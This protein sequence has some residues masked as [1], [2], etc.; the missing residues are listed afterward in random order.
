MKHE[1]IG[2]SPL[3]AKLQVKICI[4]QGCRIPDS[5]WEMRDDGYNWFDA[6]FY[7]YAWTVCLD[8]PSTAMGQR[9]FHNLHPGY[10]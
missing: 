6:A 9:G 1:S 7:V 4:V 2:D 3:R 10:V 8:R 5:I